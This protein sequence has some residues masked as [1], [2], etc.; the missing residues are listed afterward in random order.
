[1]TLKM[2]RGIGDGI[3]KETGI[4][5]EV[6]TEIWKEERTGKGMW[7]EVEIGKETGIWIIGLGL[8]ITTGK[9]MGKMCAHLTDE[10][11]G[12]AA[13]IEPT[14]REDISPRKLVVSHGKREE[15]EETDLNTESLE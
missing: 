15:I 9:E 5:I 11:L 2:E 7:T 1:M 6:E 13:W 12:H 3:L 4:E 10:G 14:R 8:E